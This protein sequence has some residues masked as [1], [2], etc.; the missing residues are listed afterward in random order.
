MNTWLYLLMAVLS[1]L[2][3][4]TVLRISRTTRRMAVQQASGPY[5]AT[6]TDENFILKAVDRDEGDLQVSWATKVGAF[7]KKSTRLSNVPPLFPPM[8]LLCSC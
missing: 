8:E 2:H 6:H 4:G 3:L 5:V 1:G 7:C